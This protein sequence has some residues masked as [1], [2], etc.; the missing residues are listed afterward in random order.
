M[1]GALGSVQ[2]AVAVAELGGEERYREAAQM[3]LANM[4]AGAMEPLRA[5]LGHLGP[6]SLRLV[7]QVLGPADSTR[8]E[9]R[10]L[11]L[12][13]LASPEHLEPL[14]DVLARAG[15]VRSIGELLARV[16]DPVAGTGARRALQG[17][18][19]RR[20][21]EVRDQVRARWTEA[22]SP[23]LCLLLGELGD[24][25]DQQKLLAALRSPDSE[26][27]VS[28]AQALGRRG[29]SSAEAGLRQAALDESAVVRAAAVRALGQVAQE[30][31]SDVLEAALAD[32]SVL[33]VLAA[34]EIVGVGGGHGREGAL[35]PLATS[36]SA[37]VALAALEAL[38]R[39]GRLDLT[40]LGA[41]SEHPHPDVVRA[42]LLAAAARPGG[43]EL[44]EV[45]LSHPRWEVRRVAARVMALAAD[46]KA[47]PALRQQE[48]RETDA[49]VVEA[50][51]EALGAIASRHG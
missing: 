8:L 47:A 16:D 29:I 36:P 37:P 38:D 25:G 21:S 35:T 41:S 28:A 12:I 48:S 17:L 33:V 42:S 26:I 15:G 40:V 6:A 24:D 49:L 2:D 46:A 51:R 32:D 50:L 1:I 20:Q 27:R 22:P 13:D 45:R 43:M 30:R 31:V 19:L 14:L 18:A 10:A 44:V 7:S 11:E 3:A 9:A 4:G 23:A 39:L 5:S 34:M